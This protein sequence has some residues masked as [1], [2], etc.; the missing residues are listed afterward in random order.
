M[1]ASTILYN[2]ALQIS[3]NQALQHGPWSSG[4]RFRTDSS[5]AVAIRPSI[6]S[7]MREA[8][9]QGR[10]TGET[11]AV[12]MGFWNRIKDDFDKPPIPGLAFADGS[13]LL[14]WRD[15]TKHA[16]VEIR[17]ALTEIYTKDR[18]TG[19]DDYAEGEGI[20]LPRNLVET[21]AR[22]AYTNPSKPLAPV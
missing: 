4:R 2:L 15:A 22:I 10:I 19:F 17:G 12:A 13:A 16:D 20:A 11:Y 18:E 9:E 21:I 5:S 7:R 3:T 14:L 1:K 8:L 6:E